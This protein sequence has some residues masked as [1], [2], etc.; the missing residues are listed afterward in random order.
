MTN[1]SSTRSRKL[2]LNRGCLLA[3]WTVVALFFVPGGTLVL[4]LLWSVTIGLPFS[5]FSPENP[6]SLHHD[7]FT[8]VAVISTGLVFIFAAFAYDWS[9]KL[10]K[11]VDVRKPARFICLWTAAIAGIGIAYHASILFSHQVIYSEGEWERSIRSKNN[12]KQLGLA[13]HNYH[14]VTNKFPPAGIVSREG[15]PQHSW[16]TMLLPYVEHGPLANR[17]DYHVPWNHRKNADAMQ[18]ELYVYLNG[19]LWEY[20]RHPDGYGMIHYA[21][22]RHLMDANS[23]TA[24]RNV[25]DGASNTIAIGE[26]TSELVPWGQPLNAR[27]PTLGLNR[28]PVGFGSPFRRANYG[29]V[30]EGCNFL[31]ADGAARWLSE[32]IDAEVLRILAEPQDGEVVGDF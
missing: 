27:D 2:S 3:A 1:G 21:A 19:S 20:S 31:F 24:M 7:W 30:S 22:N 8:W 29:R 5:L 32:D 23:R 17:I 10:E 25:T 9:M 15:V 18:A 13:L 16:A 11:S 4:V 6:F 28:S 26:V 14:D 12:L